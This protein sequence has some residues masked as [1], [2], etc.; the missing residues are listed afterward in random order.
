[1]NISILCPT[2]KRKKNVQRLIDSALNTACDRKNIEFVFYIDND[3]LETIDYLNNQTQH[4][5]ILFLNGARIILSEMWNRCY[6]KSS[7]DI[8]MLCGDDI[9][10]RSENWDT[11]VL[12]EFDKYGDKIIFVHGDDLC[13]GSN[14]GTHG[15]L[16]KN[17]I[18][19]IGYA[20]PPYFSCDFTDTWITEVSNII[21]RHI[22]LPDVITEHMH[23]SL[24]K[25]ELDLTHQERI[26]RGK[27]DNVLEIYNSLNNERK[28]DAKKLKNFIETF[29]YK[30]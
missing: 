10:F 19:T 5:N 7:S 17:W 9:V 3:D 28:E 18:K 30:K 14:L 11:K 13:H 15:F 16:H 6:E 20:A 21:K 29:Q 12:K 23:P 26:A 4:T 1:M 22:Y 2:R 24:N 27:A 8:V 25:A